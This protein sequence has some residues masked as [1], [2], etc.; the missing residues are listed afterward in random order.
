M[1]ATFNVP[2]LRRCAWAAFGLGV[3]FGVHLCVV[4]YSL[5]LGTSTLLQW[6]IYATGLSFF[7]FS[8]F[9]IAATYRPSEVAYRSFMLDHSP[10]YKIAICA[11]WVEFWLEAFFF[12]ENKA[13]MWIVLPGTLIS[14]AG[15]LTRVVGMCTCGSNFN[16]LVEE[17]RRSDHKL[18]T[19]GIYE[20][21]R[22]PSYCG[23]FW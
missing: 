18:V 13:S 11:G 9:A 5:A 7:H 21:L 1:P 4:G 19:N 15:L 12:P 16:H 10:A 3:A 14:V 20:Y 8:E 22:H 6:S 23:W 17:N 2:E